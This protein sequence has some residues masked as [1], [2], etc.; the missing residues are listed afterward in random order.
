MRILLTE[1]SGLTSRQVATRLGALGHHVEVLSST[2]LCLARF[3]RHVRKV[4]FVPNFGL[5]SLAWMDAA[6]EVCGRR[7][8]D[9]LFPT[10]EQVAILSALQENIPVKTIVPDF[11][12]LLRVQDKISA[13]RTLAEAGVPQPQTF[14]L[15]DETDL[16]K[17]DVFPAFVKR[18][19][20]TASAGVR[21]VETAAE[22]RTAARGLGLG[23]GPLIAQ[24][25]AGGRL[26]MIQALADDGRLIAFHANVRVR[27]GAGGGA[28]VKESLALPE[29]A[30]H[31]ERLLGALRWRG[32]ISFDAILTDAGPLVVDVNPRLVEPINAWRSGVD[33]V[34][35]MLDL[36]LDRPVSVQP[37]GQAGVRTHQLL[38]AILGAAQ[39]TRSRLAVLRELWLAAA[40]RGDYAHSV[41]ELTPVR[42]D[43]IAA[44]PV[45]AAAAL[46]LA[47]PPA[48]RMFERGAVRS[49]ALTPA[50]WAEIV[51]SAKGTA[52]GERSPSR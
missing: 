3:T 50:A 20:S 9:V 7:A 14:V 18:P 31:V 33:L 39:S 45:A 11:S 32:A 52:A 26:A 51:A 5:E 21:R 35:M 6:I 41:E 38:I 49:Y 34:G 25:A 44:V 19:V 46:T 30:P 28:S 29:L 16:A 42:G 37:V 13:F 24:A 22:L 36:A 2:A 27:E 47:W 4:H 15:E 40:G 43:P 1:G 8:I 12:S 10:Q 48:S 17:V 23:T